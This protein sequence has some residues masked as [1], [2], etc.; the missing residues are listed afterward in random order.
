[1]YSLWGSTPAKGHKLPLGDYTVV[2]GI[3]FRAYQSHR[4]GTM[5]I[6][7]KGAVNGAQRNALT[8]EIHNLNFKIA[9]RDF[10]LT[11][12]N[13]NCNQT[14]VCLPTR[15]P[16]RM[17]HRKISFRG[18]LFVHAQHLPTYPFS[19]HNPIQRS[20]LERSRQGNNNERLRTMGFK[21]PRGRTL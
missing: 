4:R 10:S 15:S 12:T 9:P 6:E 2:Q 20:S 3:F 21:Y 17:I 8:A 11:A 5:R 16:N 14:Q 7:K 19:R 1:M 18:M 13:N